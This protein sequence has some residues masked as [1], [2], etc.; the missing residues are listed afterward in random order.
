MLTSLRLVATHQCHE[1]DKAYIKADVLQ[2]AHQKPRIH[3]AQG[4]QPG[5]GK[6]DWSREQSADDHSGNNLAESDARLVTV[7]TQ[8]QLNMINPTALR[9]KTRVDTSAVAT[10]FFVGLG[11]FFFGLRPRH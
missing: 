11:G 3:P 10:F 8:N 1:T 6:H 7:T 5:G 2:R 4:E 9:N